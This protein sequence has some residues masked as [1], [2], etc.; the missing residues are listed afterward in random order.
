MLNAFYQLTKPGIIYGNLITAAAG[1]LLAAG[2]H[3][4]WRLLIASLV[5]TSLVIA[6]ACVFNNC[7][8]RKIDRKMARTRKR[9]LVSGVIAVRDALIFGAVLGSIGFAILIAFTNW[10]VV[11][12]G[13]AALSTYV[14]LYGLA[15]RRSIHGTLVGSLPG[16]APPL[17][18]YVAARGHFDW[19]AWLVFLIMVLWQMPHFYAIAIYRLDDYRAAA[20]PVLPVIKGITATRR[21]ITAYIVAF[22]LASIALFAFGYA[23][24][25]YL[26]IVVLAGGWWLGQSF[27]PASSDQIW[28]RRMFLSSLAVVLALA[29]AWA[30][31][32]LIP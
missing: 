16:A 11:A 2:S 31:G 19:G 24:Y 22:L 25:G 29:A 20:L 4:N 10:L 23:G 9:A 18:G 13:A 26:A 17:A 1:F 3:V 7:L 14:G 27:R 30:T 32:K 5:G 21:Q 6:S 15:K 28:A 8:D 12:I